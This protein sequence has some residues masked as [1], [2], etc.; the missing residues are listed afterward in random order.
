MDFNQVKIRC[1]SIGYIMTEPKSAADKKAGK[2]SETCKGHLSDIFVRMRY[3][4]QT[5][6]TN[7]Y[8]IKGNLVEEDSL[9][10]Y[11]QFTGKL[12]FKNKEHLTNDFITGTPDIIHGDTIIDIKSS[13]DIFTFFR[14]N[15]EKIVSNYYWQMQ[16]YMALTGAVR[17]K[18]AF[19]L[20]NT[21][22]TLIT[23]EKRRLFYRLNV[24]TEDNQEYIKGCEEI[25][26]LSIY[27]D[28]PISERV[29]EVA[30]ERN[31]E[32]I[33]AIFEKVAA[34]RKYMEEKYGRYMLIASHD[35]QVNATICESK[36]L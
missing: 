23:D 28:I 15:E 16:G 36:Q 33:D 19:C 35:P 9:T 27:D 3:N 4:R 25:E 1:S 30:I 11:S 2:L 17:A 10:L 5:D 20:V 22:D 7:K 26:K 13:W 29:I 18:L 31:Q 14:N 12:F 8:T 21:P 34:C 6:T 24:A 32:D